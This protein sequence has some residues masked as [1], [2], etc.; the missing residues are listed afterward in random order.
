MF[1]SKLKSIEETLTF[2]DILIKPNFSS[3][4][5]D[6]VDL[7]LRL[8]DNL[9]LSLPIFS[10][11]MDTVTGYEM[12]RAMIMNGCCGPL[13]KNETIANNA[14]HVAK[15]K[16]EFGDSKPI[17]VCVGV[18]NSLEDIKT[19]VDAGANVLV[20]DSAHGHTQRIGDIVQ[21]IADNFPKVYIIAGNIVTKAAAEWLVSKGAHAVKVGIGPGSICT[22]RKVT[23][24]GRGQVSS[25]AEVAEYCK[26]KGILV[27]AD[28]GISA[29]DDIMKAITCGA[30][31]IMSGFLFAGCSECPGEEITI[32]DKKYK[33]YRGMGSMSSMKLG[34]SV[35]YGKDK[36]DSGK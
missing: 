17:A 18:G 5:F 13:H 32:D 27:I 36:V 19:L 1:L 29:P 3:V 28:G 33:P 4:D 26:T 15:L 35:R 8:N 22:T 21:L 23:G 20:V 11:G 9:V 25:I 7:S 30:Q 34:S 2:D 10:A 24:I 14:V 6:K 16:A 12:A 31:A